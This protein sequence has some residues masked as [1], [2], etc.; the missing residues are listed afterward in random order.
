MAE[1]RTGAGVV[2]YEYI[3][4]FDGGI[5]ELGFCVVVNH[6][7]GQFDGCAVGCISF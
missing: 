7:A 3:E 2:I 1:E 5:F 6:N 4:L